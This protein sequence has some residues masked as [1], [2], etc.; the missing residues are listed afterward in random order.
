MTDTLTPLFAEP[1]SPLYMM[2]IEI[3]P[4]EGSEM[5]QEAPEMAGAFVDCF[6]PALDEDE[7]K[8]RLNAWLAEEQY[9]LKQIVQIKPFAE[10]DED[11]LDDEYI[12]M[13][14]QAQQSGMVYYG[15]FFCYEDTEPPKDSQEEQIQN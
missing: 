11:E 14:Q 7:A 6:V 5:A 8:E 10:C 4:L 2:Q 9:E 13:A 12:L 15:E 3:L 1:G